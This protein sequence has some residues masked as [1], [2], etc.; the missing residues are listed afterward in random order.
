MTK[1][2]YNNYDNAECDE[3][4]RGRY[5]RSDHP[6]REPRGEN[7][8]PVV[9]AAER[10]EPCH[11]RYSHFDYPP[12]E[13]R[14]RDEHTP[15]SVAAAD[16]P[17]P[18]IVPALVSHE[19]YKPLNYQ[20]SREEQSPVRF[21]GNDHGDL[22]HGQYVRGESAIRESRGIK[23]HPAAAEVFL[24]PPPPA[25]AS[26]AV[27]DDS[28]ALIMPDFVIHDYPSPRGHQ[29]PRREQSLDSVNTVEIVDPMPTPAQP[30]V[31]HHLQDAKRRIMLK[32][33]G[34][35]LAEMMLIPDVLP[36]KFEPEF[37]I[38]IKF[39]N[40]PVE[41]GQLLTINDTRTEP[42]IEF[43]TQPGQIFTLAMVDPDSPSNSRHGYRSYRH[44]LISNLDMTE[45]STT[46]VVTTY[47][48]PQPEFG[49]GAHRYA[50]V[51]LKQRD[52][53]NLTEADVPESRVR[54]DIV[55]WGNKRKM[56]PVAASYFMVKRNHVSE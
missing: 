45:N 11:G 43:D 24:P 23:G 54:F 21:D 41:M 56:K 19:Q 39:N 30:L 20:D 28:D 9:V 36:P 38:S 15:A 32:A 16:V 13:P 33:I 46:N 29:E 10:S 42:T 2:M 35:E 49:T 47:Q 37:N 7:E 3:P 22:S 52:R 25:A 8:Y 1:H 55:D 17:E 51:V 31:Q 6:L 4:S 40:K 48:G 5:D 44:F 50:L 26:A 18:Q 12:H 27:E 53:L 34:I 14:E